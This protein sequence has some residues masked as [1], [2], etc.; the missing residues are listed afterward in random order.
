MI[1]WLVTRVLY[2]IGNPLYL[3]TFWFWCALRW[4]LVGAWR[5]GAL[6]WKLVSGWHFPQR[7]WNTSPSFRWH[8]LAEH[9]AHLRAQT[10]HPH[11]R[12]LIEWI[13]YDWID[14]PRKIARG[15]FWRGAV[16]ASLGLLLFGGSTGWWIYQSVFRDLPSIVTLETRHPAATTHIYDRHGT[17]LYK[18]FEEENR[19]PVPLE[20]MSPYLV[21]ATLAIEDT[22]FYEHKGLSLKGI[23]RAAW[24]NTQNETT[25]GGST[26]TQ[27]LVKNTLLS[28]ERTWRRKIRE[29]VLAIAVDARY[30]KEQILEWYL[31]DVNFG[32]TI[33]GAEE[34]SQWYFGKPAQELDL[35]ESAL[36]AGLPNAPTYYNP[37]GSQP[38]RAEA[39]QAQV[40]RQMESL[41]FI[42]PEQR[43]S[44]QQQPLSFRSNTF[45]IKAPH[46][47][48]MVRD[49]L[50]QQYGEDVVA[51]GGLEVWTSLDLDLQA[52][53]EAAVK[54]ELDSLGRL[55]VGNGAALVTDPR[56]GEVLA[57]VGSQDYFD[58]ANDGQVNVTLRPRQPGSSIKPL[59]YALAFER[60]WSPSSTIEDSPVQF[61]AKGSPPYAPKNYD[62]RFR[63]TVSLRESLGSSYNI[64]A[65][66]L[67]ADVGVPSLIRL[68][69]Q[70]GISTWDDPARFGLALTLGG[71]EITMYD[72]AQ[73]YGTF[74]NA[75][76]TV[77][78][79]PILEIYDV[80][81]KQI[82]RNPCRE[83]N[84]PCN[85]E[86][87]LQPLTAMQ[88]TDV[89]SDN[90]AR[91][92]AFGP[93][94]ALVIPNQE[95]A[96]KS[97]TTNSLRDNWTIGYTRDRVVLT[98]VG[99]NDNTPMSAVASGVTGASPIWNTLMSRVLDSKQHRF[100]LPAGLE[101]VKLCAQTRTLAC[102]ACPKIVEEVLPVERIPKTTC[103]PG[104]FARASDT[105]APVA[106]TEEENWNVPTF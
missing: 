81:G 91:T 60:G 4:V 43:E 39:R 35:A 70:M 3:L 72:M 33:Y 90:N 17:L 10:L 40:L 62:G 18:I 38:E 75:G 82:Y 93:N 86:R 32:G 104:D 20:Q 24:H 67:L 80:Q 79:N 96:V 106:L 103:Q 102:D 68:G 2:L 27:Q 51:Q 19:T 64:P 95:V 76:E 92:P 87:V 42:T 97:G 54:K 28:R 100:A 77:P 98:W 29:G 61:T 23:V 34:A 1:I 85:G 71:G 26:I 69:Q 45:D 94:S 57:M 15:I 105:P 25:H 78:L 83:A 44:A 6:L 65:V 9:V 21:Q 66:R 50:A 49:Q 73:V 84:D 53:A 88:I 101:R 11:E 16:A 36:L 48:M 56:S 52:S 58:T 46:F 63:G 8:Q 59:T 47:V 74:A 55:R 22:Q 30:P 5:Q 99:N 7:K 14:P 41:G 12:Q 37:F 89:L 13:S 31:N